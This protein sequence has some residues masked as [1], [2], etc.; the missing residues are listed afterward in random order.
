MGFDSCKCSKRNAQISEYM[1]WCFL[2][3]LSSESTFF[4]VWSVLWAE[5]EQYDIEPKS[6]AKMESDK[7]V[8]W[9][10]CNQNKL[11]LIFTKSNITKLIANWAVRCFCFYKH[12]SVYSKLAIVSSC[13]AVILFN[14]NLHI[15]GVP[16]CFH[17]GHKSNLLPPWIHAWKTKNVDENHISVAG[18]NFIFFLSLCYQYE[19][20]ACDE[21]GTCF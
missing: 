21:R 11:T 8:A 15:N 7:S 2:R 6:E 19:S 9:N 13:V 5:M 17:Y 16:N 3:P 14:L 4:L 12:F 18:L 10:A 20:S 1:K